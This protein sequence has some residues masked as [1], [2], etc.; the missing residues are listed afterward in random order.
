MALYEV[1]EDGTIVPKAGKTV[2]NLDCLRTEVVYD[3]T[4]SDSNKNWGYTSGINGGI[5]VS[6][7]DFSKYKYL[8]ITC[9][10]NR[11]SGS[12]NN[13]WANTATLDL[14][15]TRSA[16]SGFFTSLITASVST[17]NF[18]KVV[19]SIQVNNAKTSISL[20]NTALDSSGNGF[21]AGST[22]LSIIKIEGV[23]KTPAMI[24][25][26]KEL[27]AGNGISIDNGV[28]SSKGLEYVGYYSADGNVS[29]DI[30]LDKYDYFAF[31][32]INTNSSTDVNLG[33][34]PN[35]SFN[36][37]TNDKSASSTFSYCYLFYAKSFSTSLYITYNQNNDGYVRVYPS[38]RGVTFASSTS[39]P[40]KLTTYSSG[41]VTIANIILYRR[42]K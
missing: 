18:Y 16:V 42:K 3:M 35:T 7:K 23:L 22:D 19:A 30:D 28:V 39:K 13:T 38:D 11:A 32:R 41:T 31:V 20:T 29:V 15:V 26:G 8:I 10:D 34:F 2:G 40:T 33:I 9:A 14:T 27:F 24:Y 17:S 4:S 37:Y 1:L 21:S 6:G 36:V 25:T 5:T 12:V